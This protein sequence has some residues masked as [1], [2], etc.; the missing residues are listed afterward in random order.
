MDDTKEVAL[1]FLLIVLLQGGERY[2]HT[3]LCKEEMDAFECR[4]LLDR[5]ELLSEKVIVLQLV[6]ELCL[7]CTTRSAVHSMCKCS[8]E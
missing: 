6:I 3:F 5:M 1:C 8:I 4:E 2:H 7:P